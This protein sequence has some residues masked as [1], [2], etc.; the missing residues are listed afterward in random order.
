MNDTALPRLIL[1]APAGV[2]PVDCAAAAC[3]V[4]DC[5]IIVVGEEISRAS[6]EALQAQ[7]LAVLLKDCEPRKVHHLKADGLLLSTFENFVDARSALKNESLGLLA[8]TSRHAAM[9]AAEAG[10]DFVAFTQ[11]KQY[12]GEP[13][14]GWWQDLTDVP[15]I[16][17]DPVDDAKLKPQMPDFIR[18]DDSMWV[19]RDEAARVVSLL[20]AQWT[21]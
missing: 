13:I 7:D 3:K 4:A 2:D 1:V 8:G 12:A 6:V 16:A 18:P 21:Q 14:I 10:A 11:T 9:E 17:F 5:A 20:M 15:S 19:N